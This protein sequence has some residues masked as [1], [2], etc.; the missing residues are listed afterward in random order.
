MTIQELVDLRLSNQS[1][2]ERHFSKP[3]D[4]LSS[5]VGIQGQDY[6][7]AK[8]SMALR[9]AGY[10]DADIERAID[11]R[12]II[13]TWPMR[14][15]L[16]FVAA[17]DIRWI[18]GLVGPHVIRQATSRY[19]QLGLTGPVLAKAYEILQKNLDKQLLT[20]D[21]IASLLEDGGIRMK[22]QR[23]SHILQ[24]ASANQLI[25]FGSRRGNQFTFTL[26]D[27]VVSAKSLSTDKA[28]AQLA[29][30]YFT[31]RGPA[32]LD[33]FIWWSGLSPK[34]CRE[35]LE[36]IDRKLTKAEIANKTYYYIPSDVPLKA[37]KV[38]LLPGFDEYLL[39]YKDR[40][41]VLQSLKHSSLA[42]NNGMFHATVILNGKVCGTWKRTL[43]KDKVQIDFKPFTKIS[44]ADKKLIR[45]QAAVYADYLSV[46]LIK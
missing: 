13:R 14:G 31:T 2:S 24:H 15:T 42:H 16:H 8:W 19:R 23:L 37:Q 26:L 9:L 35:A 12:K 22:E 17:K 29:L 45:E 43:V 38:F 11:K 30:R 3:E 44:A 1:I 18:L 5:M 34:L 39:A 6:F 10:N 21:E 27:E 32:T 40:S 28:L 36:M 41:A 46:E 7:G 33:D 25:C 20:R 4:L